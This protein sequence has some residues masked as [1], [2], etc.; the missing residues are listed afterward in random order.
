RDDDH[1]PAT[2]VRKGLDGKGGERRRDKFLVCYKVS[3]RPDDD[4]AGAYVDCRAVVWTVPVR[5]EFNDSASGVTPAYPAEGTAK[6]ILGH[7]RI[8][9]CEG[10]NIEGLEN[11]D[12][13]VCLCRQQEL[14][15][16]GQTEIPKTGVGDGLSMRN[17]RS[18]DFEVFAKALAEEVVRRMRHRLSA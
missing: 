12:E 10:A 8:F 13:R 6:A 9:S 14:T 7:F 11:L 18:S 5:D 15:R 16:L 2:G 4:V 3:P 1:C 17:V